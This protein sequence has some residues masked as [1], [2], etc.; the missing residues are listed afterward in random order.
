MPKRRISFVTGGIGRQA[1]SKMSASNTN[2]P[3][4]TG[5]TSKIKSLIALDKYMT[6]RAM[7]EGVEWAMPM[8]HLEEIYQTG[9]RDFFGVHLDKNQLLH[10][11][12][13]PEIFAD[14]HKMKELL[15]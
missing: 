2:A 12:Q 9:C 15:Q 10:D 1:R 7:L 13:Q 14:F 6:Y 11:L 3:G 5:N 4:A 8:R